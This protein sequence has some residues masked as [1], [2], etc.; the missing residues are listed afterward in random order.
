MSTREAQ[1]QKH[2]KEIAL[3]IK[4]KGPRSGGPG[5]VVTYINV[6]VNHMKEQHVWEMRARI[7]PPTPGLSCVPAHAY[8]DYDA[9]EQD[10]YRIAVVVGVNA[11]PA[12]QVE[13]V[14]SLNRGPGGLPLECRRFFM[15]EGSGHHAR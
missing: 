5:D 10:R 2:N 11:P 9:G 14:V 3:D 12:T 15:V 6:I 8:L 7:D 4:P 13:L 1:S